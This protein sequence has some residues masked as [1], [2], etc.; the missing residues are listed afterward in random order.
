MVFVV[1]LFD[2]V[3]TIEVIIGF[4]ALEVALG[5]IEVLTVLVVAVVVVVVVTALPPERSFPWFQVLC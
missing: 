3:L 2:V 4:L 5:F 1:K